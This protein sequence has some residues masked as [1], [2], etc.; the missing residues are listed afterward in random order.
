[1]QG[2]D[3]GISEAAHC[4]TTYALYYVWHVKKTIARLETRES[5]VPSSLCI[6]LA[7]RSEEKI[8][9]DI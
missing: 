7:Q 9:F 5:A 1:M 4:H 6:Q 3:A 8:R 2:K